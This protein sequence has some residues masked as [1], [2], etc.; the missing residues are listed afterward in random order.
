LISAFKK[1]NLLAAR[2]TGADSC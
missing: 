1:A 2:V